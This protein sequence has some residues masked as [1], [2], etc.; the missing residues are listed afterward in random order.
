MTC[1]TQKSHD[2]QQK[3]MK[4]MG[5]NKVLQIGCKGLQ[6]LEEEVEGGQGSI[7]A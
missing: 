1:D 5:Y 2:G 3:K 6:L 4:T 7:W